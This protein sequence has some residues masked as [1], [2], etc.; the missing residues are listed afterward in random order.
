MLILSSRKE[1]G[2]ALAKI[3]AG[4][5]FIRVALHLTYVRN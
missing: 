3:M 5:M 1:L 4:A 2:Y